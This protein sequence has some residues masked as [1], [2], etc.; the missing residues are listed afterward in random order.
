MAATRT[1]ANFGQ[2]T[3]DLNAIIW[4]MSLRF[5]DFSHNHHLTTT[6]ALCG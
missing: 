4:L 2:M 3:S 6:D 5:T 1:N